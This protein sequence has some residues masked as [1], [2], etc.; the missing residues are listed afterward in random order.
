[1]CPSVLVVG[2][3]VI[4]VKFFFLSFS[5]P[6]F[7]LGSC[8]EKILT[9]KENLSFGVRTVTTTAVLCWRDYQQHCFFG[10]RFFFEELYFSGGRLTLTFSFRLLQFGD[11]RKT[12][13]F[14]GT[15][16]KEGM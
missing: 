11:N 14:F 6:S 8:G 16:V 4:A 13:R 3:F 15:G 9:R 12:I 5:E 1:M 2:A 10:I 7:F